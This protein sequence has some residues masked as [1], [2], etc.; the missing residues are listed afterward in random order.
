MKRKKKEE[1]K[2]SQITINI[3]NFNFY[4]KIYI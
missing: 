3:F 2:E 4:E 1:Y